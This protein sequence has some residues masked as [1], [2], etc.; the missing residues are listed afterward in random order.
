MIA[1]ILAFMGTRLGGGIAAAIAAVLVLGLGV[2]TARL[3]GAHG[4][5]AKLTDRIEN[6]RTGYI[7]KLSTCQGNVAGLESAVKAQ[8]NAVAAMGAE[9][10]RKMDAASIAV[11]AAI[12]GRASAEGRAAKLLRAPPAGIDACARMQA[13][14]SAVLETL[15]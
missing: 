5:V 7:A 14:D 12:Q 15:Q 3:A 4:D 1:A 10:A 8:N 6:P 13:A 9:S 2:Q 11:T